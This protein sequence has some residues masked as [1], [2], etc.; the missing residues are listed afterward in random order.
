MIIY[1]TDVMRLHPFILKGAIFMMY[2]L[3]ASAQSVYNQ[4]YLQILDCSNPFRIEYAPVQEIN[5]ATVFHGGLDDVMG[6]ADTITL[7]VDGRVYDLIPVPLTDAMVEKLEFQPQVVTGSVNEI[8]K[9]ARSILRSTP[10][11]ELSVASK[12]SLALKPVEADTTP[13]PEEEADD[14]VRNASSNK[15]CEDVLDNGG[16]ADA[17]LRYLMVDGKYLHLV[18]LEKSSSKNQCYVK[19]HYYLTEDE[20]YKTVFS[21]KDRHVFETL[22]DLLVEGDLDVDVQFNSTNGMCAGSKCACMIIESYA[23]RIG[24]HDLKVTEAVE[25]QAPIATLKAGTVKPLSTLADQS[26]EDT[27]VAEVP[28][29]AKDKPVP[30]GYTEKDLRL[31]QLNGRCEQLD[32]NNNCTL[33]PLRYIRANNK[34]V[35]ITNLLTAEDL[36][37]GNPTHVCVEYFLSDNPN[38]KTV[39]PECDHT[40][41][42]VIAGLLFDEGKSDV[43]VGMTVSHE[44]HGSCT[45]KLCERYRTLLEVN[46]VEPIGLHEIDEP[47]QQV[48]CNGFSNSSYLIRCYNTFLKVRDAQLNDGILSLTI[49]PTLNVKEATIFPKAWSLFVDQLLQ[50]INNLGLDDKFNKFRLSCTKDCD[51][52]NCLPLI[53]KNATGTDSVNAITKIG[54]LTLQ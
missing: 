22:H 17:P 43:S 50:R 38:A 19:A 14:F 5:K 35:C 20:T 3:L 23:S 36:E 29:Q 53:L 39:F 49:S 2:V 21:Q 37:N 42:T 54:F 40:L 9:K 46:H 52:S 47:T 44:G 4:F 8:V 28:K 15:F 16:C 11:F 33:T 30:D 18:K 48:K 12:S 6:V 7:G 1:D 10:T 26:Q 34:Y 13:T 41:C 27:W 51:G 31:E 25:M 45:W 32:N 24:D